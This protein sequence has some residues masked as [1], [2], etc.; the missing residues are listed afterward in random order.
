[1]IIRLL[2]LALLAL[3]LSAFGA[4]TLHATTMPGHSFSI[5]TEDFL[6]DGQPYVIRCGEIHFP[7]VPREYWRH[8]LQM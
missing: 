6:L 4:K 8:R 7:R 1:M 3:S 2:R 5:A